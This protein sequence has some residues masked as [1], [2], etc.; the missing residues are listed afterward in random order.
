M[1]DH[2][3]DE[4]DRE[5][6]A[7]VNG[8]TP[9]G[10]K[11]AGVVVPVNRVKELE[12]LEWLLDRIHETGAILGSALVAGIF[13]AATV[14]GWMEM[15]FGIIVTLAVAARAAFLFWRYRHGRK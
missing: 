9:A 10:D 1:S 2:E 4:A 13:F 5:L 3:Y 7:M 14:F 11:T 8:E 6:F 15:I 12:R